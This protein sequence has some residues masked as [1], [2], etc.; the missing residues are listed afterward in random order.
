MD[1]DFSKM[2]T[3]QLWEIRT[4]INNELSIRGAKL[5]KPAASKK[6]AMKSVFRYA[7]KG[8]MPDHVLDANT[9]LL[10]KMPISNREVF[11]EKRIYLQCIL[12]Q[13]WMYLFDS[14]ENES[15]KFYV[16][17]H[18]D[19]IYISFACQ[20]INILPCQGR[21]FYIGKGTGN[22][23][24]DLKRNQ[25]HGKMIANL[26][27]KGNKVDDIAKILFDGLSERKAMELESKLIYFF[28]TIYEKNRKGTLLNLDI[29]KRPEFV[30]TMQ[31]SGI[32]SKVSRLLESK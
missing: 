18:V 8:D 2:P 29:S 27:D 10:L 20:E 24:H 30:G 5:E 21:P 9:K 11:D 1:L 28:G 6:Q 31:R 12:R 13:D 15:A 16:Y 4:S 25:G 14:Y 19:P 17:A 23:S 3:F 7:N 22:R 26:L 32:S